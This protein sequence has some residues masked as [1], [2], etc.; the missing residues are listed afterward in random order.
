[1]P[2]SVGRFSKKISII[3][4][5]L[6]AL[7]VTSAAGH[8]RLPDGEVETVQEIT[9]PA[10]SLEGNLLGTPT[11]QFATIYLPPSYNRDPDR[12]FPVLYLLHGHD[13]TDRTWL[14]DPKAP[15]RVVVNGNSYSQG[16]WLK[17][18]KLDELFVA[19]PEMIIVA[20]NGRNALKD[21]NWHDSPV[22]GNWRE[23]VAV[24]LIG[25]IDA[26][27]RTIPKREGR[28]VAGHSGGGY[29][30]LNLAMHDAD[31]FSVA[32]A[33][34]P[35]CLDPDST[36][37]ALTLEDSREATPFWRGVM[38][39]IEAL[40]SPTDLPPSS[41]GQPKQFF[42]TVELSAAAS[43]SPN[44]TKGPFFGDLLFHRE[45]GIWLLDTDVFEKR[46]DLRL[47]GQIEEREEALRSLNGLMIDYGEYELP[48]L[49][50]GN[51]KFAQA[52]AERGIPFVFEVYSDGD[53]GN[54]VASRLM[55]VGLPFVAKHLASE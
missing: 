15:E 54:L 4:S 42:M 39:N 16:G 18:E 13:G 5:L 3:L 41:S 11:E 51:A 6:L 45:N 32:Y 12:R 38:D 49:V 35:C 17:R 2:S 50:P 55:T 23:F 28:A 19:I 53:H 31:L 34:A 37:P 40:D 8:D 47:Y 22:T 14:I 43:Y 36:G 27:Y 46:R 30:A 24:D 26:K 21:G 25:Y 44:P 29:G 48:F 9:V 20:P 33:M 10:P 52:L 1:M 7:L